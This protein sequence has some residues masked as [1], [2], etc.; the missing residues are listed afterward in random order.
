MAHLRT[1]ARQ[2]ERGSRLVALATAAA[3]LVAAC[4]GGTTTSPV[5]APASPT[6]A[7]ATEAPPQRGRDGT[8]TLFFW[9]APTTLN[10]HLSPGTK[11]YSAARLTYEPLASFDKDGNLVPFL[12]AEIPSLENGGVA[13]DGM[14]VTW[15]L[16]P[17]LRWSDGE[18]FTAEDVRF[19]WQY[20]T[21]PDV[22]STS[23][24]AF[25][26]VKDVVVVDPQTVR[27]EFKERDPAWATP[28]VGVQGLILPKHVF[29][30][31]KGAAAKDAPP[32]LAPVGTGPFRVTSFGVEDV[33]IVGGEAVPTTKVLYEANPYYRD[34]D[35]PAFSNVVLQGGGGDAAVAVQAITD[36]TADYA[37]NL[38]VDDATAAQ[39]EASGKGRIVAVP[40]AFVERIMLNF[41]DPNTEAASGERSSTEHPHPFLTDKAVRQ[42]IAL[43]V[44]REAI[45]A[46]YGRGGT[47]TGNILMSPTNVASSRPPTAYDPEAAKRLLDEAGWTDHDGDGVRDK[48]GVPLKLLYQTSINA[49]RQ[50]AQEIVK[51]SLDAIGFDVELKNIDSGVFF[52]PPEGTTSTRRQ[53]YADLEEFAFSNKVPDP[54]AYMGAWTCEQ[55]AQQAN[56]WSGSNW[57]R[58]CDPAYDAL[59]QQAAA[60]L[61]PAKRAELF[62]QLNDYLLDDAAVIPLVRLAD[63]SGISSSVEGLE[64]TPWD[65][66]PWSIAD[67]HRD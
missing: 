40:G 35:K 54:T 36:G 11:D 7:Q 67:W 3:L 56:D 30:P 27:V 4:G 13:A 12:A 29:E 55:A 1:S 47:A 22:A 38:Q 52:G 25:G 61:D 21:D 66:D 5:A 6:A 49:V 62:K 57:S 26:S 44:D 18:P 37:W 42:A 33:L 41:S 63:M 20:A 50:Q 58:Y 24:A 16:R 39:V 23:G 10:P 46:L 60:E 17:D 8:L 53:F 45:A 64:L 48:G 65:V 31:F 34:P 14:S 28:F 59:W 9:Q 15:K 2:L 43:A 32:N 19:T 51:A